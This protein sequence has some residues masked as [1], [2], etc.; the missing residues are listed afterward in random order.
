MGQSSKALVAAAAKR[1][2]ALALHLQG[3]SYQQI[4]DA[5]GYNSRSAAHNAVR[6][7]LTDRQSG[8]TGPVGTTEA[9]ETEAARVDVVIASLSPAVR[10]GDPASVNAYLKAIARRTA[11]AGMIAASQPAPVVQEVKSPLD[12]LRERRAARGAGSAGAGRASV[13]DKRG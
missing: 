4:A 7:A 12:E 11:L 1:Q 3:A 13:A 6:T 2:K 10:M 5:V 8:D 9:F